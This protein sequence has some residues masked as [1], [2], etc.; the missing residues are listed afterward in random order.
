MDKLVSA[1]GIERRI[2][3]AYHPRTNGQTERFNHVLIDSL[4]KYTEENPLEWPKWIPFVLLAYRS[5]IHSTTGF[6]PFELMFGRKMNSFDE[7]RDTPISDDSISLINRSN[8]IKDLVNSGQPKALDN[9]KNK[10]VIQKK[11]QD[12]NSKVT[13]LMLKTGTQVYVATKGLHNKLHPRYVG[14]YVVVKQA[15]GGNYI[16]KNILGEQLENSFPLS[17]LKIIHESKESADTDQ[18]N[19]YRVEKIIDH[20]KDSKNK[21]FY[22]VKWEKYS[23]KHN[24]WE[25]AENFIDKNVI[26]KYW[27][28]VNPKTK[29]HLYKNNNKIS[30]TLIS[31]LCLFFVMITGV[32]SEKNTE[33][34]GQFYFCENPSINPF[35]A[36][37]L[38]IENGCDLS[39]SKS[40]IFPTGQQF[41]NVHVLDKLVHEVQGI[42]YECKKLKVQME[43]SETFF[44]YP[45]VSYSYENRKLSRK[46]CKSMVDT[47]ACAEND[48]ICNDEGCSYDG[49]PKERYNWWGVVRE[50]GIICSFKQKTIIAVNSTT[51]LFNSKCTADDLWCKL[52]ESTIVWSKDVIQKCPYGKVTFINELS[53]DKD[54]IL[55]D[56]VGSRAFK[57][58]E[59]LHNCNL[60]LYRS[61]EGLYLSTDNDAEKLS[62]TKNDLTSLH[63]LMLTEEDGIEYITSERLDIAKI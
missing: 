6:T 26:K 31:I 59:K 38:N 2:T 16:L 52:P 18:D 27:E 32:F 25:P 62:E 46:E 9:I 4:R 47:R 55:I 50:T 15:T 23:S 21:D 44:G 19:L 45:K 11:N 33:I 56:R 63:E 43:T 12:K 35:E 10:Q 5:K 14:P 28:K 3:S 40:K 58:V 57:I 54:D 8:E 41:K 17:R 37:I 24:T 7:Y 29:R 60:T 1:V 13:E 48:M 61:T 34:L 30:N 53:H 42:A 49:T 39:R 20:K 36:S 22:L 51:N